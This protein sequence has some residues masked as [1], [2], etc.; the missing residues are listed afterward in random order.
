MVVLALWE[1]SVVRL[2]N[3]SGAN[4]RS[5][6]AVDSSSVTGRGVG[7]LFPR[8]VEDERSSVASVLSSDA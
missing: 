1:E 5:S 3:F 7:D 8:G 4:N 6:S 2:L